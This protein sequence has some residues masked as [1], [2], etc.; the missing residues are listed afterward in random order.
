[1]KVNSKHK[2]L[3]LLVCVIIQAIFPCLLYADVV[4]LLPSQEFLLGCARE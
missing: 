2:T 4:Y 1:M 3:L